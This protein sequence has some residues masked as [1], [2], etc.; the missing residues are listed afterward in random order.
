M[1]SKGTMSAGGSFSFP[2]DWDPVRKT[3][4]SINCAP[5]FG[6]FV[7]DGL[8][9]R[10]NAQLK[11]PLLDEGIALGT[12]S[13][14]WLWGFGMGLQYIFDMPWPVLPFVG[15]DLGFEMA[16]LYL[17]T[18]RANI[19]IPFGILL[20]LNKSIALSFGINT[21]IALIARLQL[22][23]RLRIEPGCLGIKVVF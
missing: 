9:L 17:M 8:E 10:L 1:L 20:P 3:T 22:F 4:F 5:Q 7:T 6:Y 15:F 16:K 13:S 21:R 12:R 14:R 2:I 23:D 19:D 18:W 11:T